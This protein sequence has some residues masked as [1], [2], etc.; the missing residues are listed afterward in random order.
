MAILPAESDTAS[1]ENAAH[2]FEEGGGGADEKF[3]AD[4]AAGRSGALD[5]RARQRRA[6]CAQPV[7]L[8]IARDK[9]GPH[10]HVATP[11]AGLYHLAI[12]ITPA[13]GRVNRSEPTGR[14][15][16]PPCCRRSAPERAPSSSR[17]CSDC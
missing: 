7:H 15:K 17:F 9:F 6:V 2:R 13:L 14:G 16:L 1:G 3:A 4:L 5:K 8:P 12:T 11:P 10:R